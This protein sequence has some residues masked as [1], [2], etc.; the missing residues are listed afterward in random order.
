MKPGYTKLLIHDVVIPPT[1]ATPLAT[2][3]DLTMM[4]LFGA[5]ERTLAD[6]R[7]LIEAADLELENVWSGPAYRDSL[8]EI[9]RRQ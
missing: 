3:M 4:S 1:N 6:F 8:L 2:G 5:K 9:V 7:S